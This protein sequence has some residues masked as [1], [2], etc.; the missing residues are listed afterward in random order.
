MGCAVGDFDEDGL[1][2]FYGTS[3][4]WST[5]GG[6]MLWMSEGGHVYD[7]DARDRGVQD[8]AWG[9]GT[10]QMDFD[11]DGLLDLV[12]T[13][14]WNSAEFLGE[15]TR[16]FHNQGNAYFQDIAVGAGMNHDGQGRGLA[17]LDYDRDGDFDLAIFSNKEPFQLWR[18]D[19]D[20]GNWLQVELDTSAHPGLAPDGFGTRV[21]F[22]VGGQAS[23]RYLDGGPSYLA[24]L[25]APARDG[26]RG[27]HSGRP[28]GGRMGG[29]QPGRA[30]G[31]GGQ[32]TPALALGPSLRGT[33]GS[34][35][36]SDR[37]TFPARCPSF[38]AGRLPGR[39]RRTGCRTLP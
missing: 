31:R 1:L 7:E 6:N 19:T 2:D 23:V 30:T 18:N 28:S 25:G 3:I 37:R 39:L 36:G 35:P 24:T 29:R 15:T 33:G 9:W 4:A 22:E 13:N 26:P 16:L 20:G 12:E 5:G 34:F 17:R 8:G 10:L 27:S 21:W 11:H 38:R 32:P 14:G